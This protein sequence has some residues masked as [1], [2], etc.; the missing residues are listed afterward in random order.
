MAN[1]GLSVDTTI[2]S[3]PIK[4]ITKHSGDPNFQAIRDSHNHLKSNAAS[5]LAAIGGGHFGLIGLIIQ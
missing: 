3:F 4:D 1:N 2:D 5:I